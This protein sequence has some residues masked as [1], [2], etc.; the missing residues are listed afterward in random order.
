MNVLPCPAVLPVVF[1]AGPRQ[2]WST[3]QMFLIY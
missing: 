2:I 1:F 3:A